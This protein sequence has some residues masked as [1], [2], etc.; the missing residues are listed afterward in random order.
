MW[1]LENLI[2]IL[3]AA[4]AREFRLWKF[5]TNGFLL[6]FLHFFFIRFHELCTKTLAFH[7]TWYQ[8][9]LEEKFKIKKGDTRKERKKK[10]EEDPDLI[11]I[12]SLHRRD[13]K[14]KKSNYWKGKGNL[15]ACHVVACTWRPDCVFALLCQSRLCTILIVAAAWELFCLSSFVTH[16]GLFCPLNLYGG[17]VSHT[18]ERS[19]KEECKI[20]I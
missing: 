2:Y 6:L 20:N 13:K 11:K 15:G 9:R 1:N 17:W 19:K 16:V 4:H 12:F 7:T 8:S 14:E 10:E 5:F 3:E 18:H